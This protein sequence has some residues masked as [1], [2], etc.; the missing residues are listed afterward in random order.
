[1]LNSQNVPF[2]VDTVAADHITSVSGT[3]NDC[4]GQINI[5]YGLIKNQ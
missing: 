4:D 2:S 5:S 3:I 1:M